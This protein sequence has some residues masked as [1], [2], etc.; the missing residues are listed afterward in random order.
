MGPGSG[1]GKALPGK[2]ELIVAP[3][4]KHGRKALMP[5]E[6]HNLPAEMIPAMEQGLPKVLALRLD[7]L[8]LYYCPRNIQQPGRNMAVI[9]RVLRK[10]W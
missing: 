3:G 1:K 6:N 8:I 9:G 4:R 2:G 10:A 7:H 5:A